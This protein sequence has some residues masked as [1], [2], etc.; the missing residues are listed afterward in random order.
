[1]PS[2]FKVDLNGPYIDADP[3][4][5]AD[6]S[7]SSWLE[8]LNF[9]AVDF[10]ILPVVPGVP[11]NEVINID[12]VVIDGRTYAPGQIASAWIKNLQPGVTYT[13]NVAGTFT[14]GRKDERSFRMVCKEL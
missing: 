8:G 6:Y 2:R 13:V 10:S 5:D 3:G 4:S 14:G 1:M 7:V 11:Y 9:T 12:P